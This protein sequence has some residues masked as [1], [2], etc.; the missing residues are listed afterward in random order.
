M[1]QGSPGDPANGPTIACSRCDREYD[2]AYELEELQV[3]NQAVEKF[4][5]DH[6]RHTGH[7]P[8]GVSTWEADCRQCPET[9][10][11]LDEDAAVRWARTHARHTRHSVEVSHADVEPRIVEDD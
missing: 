1:E 3:G 11:R 8:D 7:F 10:A 4:A 2:L 6:R 9:V 5:L